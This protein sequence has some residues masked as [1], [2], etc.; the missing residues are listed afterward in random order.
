MYS[1]FVRTY[2]ATF[3]THTIFPERE[4]FVSRF[5]LRTA[6]GKQFTDQLNIVIIELDKLNNALKKPVCELTS[7]E[8]WSLFFKFA[9]DPVHRELINDIIM[10]KEEIG[11]AATLLREIS[12]D[13][14][15]RARL[16]SRRMY[17]TDR[18]SDLL[19]AE[20]RGEIKGR[21]KERLKLQS[22]IADKDIL[23][24]SKDAT[25]ADKDAAIADYNILIADK[26]VVIADKDAEILRLRK[27][28]ADNKI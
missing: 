2:Q 20:A 7:F 16:R 13:E 21:K 6:D 8:K 22:T 19:T 25:I 10:E 24:A 1:D 27:L 18:I 28:I 4:D 23:I 15:E 17:E 14:H 11:M 3:S 9:S 5:S 12:K 26:D